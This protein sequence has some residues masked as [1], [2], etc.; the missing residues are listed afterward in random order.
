MRRDECPHF[1]F[2]RHRCNLIMPSLNNFVGDPIGTPPGS[3]ALVHVL[4]RPSACRPM[5]Q[6]GHWLVPVRWCSHP[7]QDRNQPRPPQE[8]LPDKARPACRASCE[9]DLMDTQSIQVRMS[10][11]RNC[12][13]QQR[14]ECGMRTAEYSLTVL[15]IIRLVQF[16]H[17]VFPRLV[18]FPELIRRRE[19]RHISKFVTRMGRG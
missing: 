11:R 19:C 9:P 4:P 3:P 6:L 12:I 15:S 17:A 16:P 1:A 18:A 2:R 13:P 14:Q 8:R 5:T 7:Q 10:V